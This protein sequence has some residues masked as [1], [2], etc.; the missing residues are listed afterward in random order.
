MEMNQSKTSRKS[1]PG[2]NNMSRQMM[3]ILYVASCQKLET[4]KLTIL[5]PCECY[6]YI[7]EKKLNLEKKKNIHDGNEKTNSIS[8]VFTCEDST[9]R[10]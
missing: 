1:C 5:T 9:L 8:K 6:W 2:E 10:N 7:A 3:F 4:D